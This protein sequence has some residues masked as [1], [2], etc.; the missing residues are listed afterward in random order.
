MK[1]ILIQT[2]F[3]AFALIANAQIIHLSYDS[4]GNRIARTLLNSNSYNARTRGVT[5]N[6]HEETANI[7]SLE[8]DCGYTIY[9]D[10]PI[11]HIKFN[12]EVKSDRVVTIFS[13]AGIR[14][15]S[16]TSNNNEFAFDL[17]GEKSSMFVMTIKEPEMDIQI[18]KILK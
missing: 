14:L 6:N 18:V 9:F 16:K 8:R 5:D 4:S 3:C 1:K 7:S 15:S 11:L 13:L 17:A 12:D 10:G 2:L